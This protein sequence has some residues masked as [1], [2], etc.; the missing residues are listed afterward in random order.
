MAEETKDSA[1]DV[2]IEQPLDDSAL[3]VKKEQPVTEETKPSLVAENASHPESKSNDSNAVQAAEPLK[4]GNS[5]AAKG[6]SDKVLEGQKWNNRTRTKRDFK[7][8]VKSDLTSQEDS[9][10]PVAIRKQVR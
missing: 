3:D 4:N 5:V 6:T 10:D 1:L 7:K 8:N 9:S 2:K